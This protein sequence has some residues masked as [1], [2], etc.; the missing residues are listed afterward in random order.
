MAGPQIGFLRGAG[1]L[2]W[3]PWEELRPAPVMTFVFPGAVSGLKG[4]LKVMQKKDERLGR[5]EGETLSTP[6]IHRV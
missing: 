5:V 3:I 2:A 1:I 6:C 4:S